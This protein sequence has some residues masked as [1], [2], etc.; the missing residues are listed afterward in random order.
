[1]SV[2][3]LRV[4]TLAALTLA[5]PMTGVAQTATDDGDD[6]LARLMEELRAQRS[7]IAAQRQRLERHEAKLDRLQDLIAAAASGA[8]DTP[9]VLDTSLGGALGRRE[10]DTVRGAGQPGRQTAQATGDGQNAPARSAS[11]SQAPPEPERPEVPVIADQGGV[12]A[13][14]GEFVLEPAVEYTN[15]SSTR[16]EVNGFTVLPAI[17][18]GDFSISRV[19]SETITSSLTARYGVTDTFEVEARV[20]YVYRTEDAVGRPIGEGASV[21]EVTSADGDGLGDIE[22][23][24]H[25]QIP[26]D[27]TGDNFVVA[28]LRVKSRTGT[29]PFEVARDDDGRQLELATGTG[30]WSVEPSVSFIRPTDPAVLFGSL[31]YNYTVERDIGG[32]FGEIDPGDEI[33]A[34]VGF[35]L[36][37]NEEFSI[38]TSYDH[39]MV[40]ETE[41][42][43]EPV[44]GGRE[45]QIGRLLFGGTYRFSPGYSFTATIGAGLTE[46]APDLAVTLRPTIRF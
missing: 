41:Q 35:G 9:M 30:F 46:D 7:E 23:A 16:V 20:P 8:A 5:W 43:G 42:N 12:L 22:A 37:L 19:E 6:R 2:L 36:S 15:S 44:A 27:W 29:D 18:I 32:G 25:Y 1:M 21:D 28:N 3:G 4:A 24:L 40:F 14:Q 39:T 33:G 31:S 11:P 10:A 38:S 34:S 26:K 45:L 17:L 13:R